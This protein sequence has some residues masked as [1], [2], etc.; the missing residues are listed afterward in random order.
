MVYRQG[1]GGNDSKQGNLGL[2]KQGNDGKHGNDG[3]QGNVGKQG[4]PGKLGNAR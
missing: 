4:N 3:E 1:N 2:S